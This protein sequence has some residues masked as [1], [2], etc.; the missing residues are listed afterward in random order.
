[1]NQVD[2]QIKQLADELPIPESG[3]HTAVLIDNEKTKVI[4]FS[5]ASVSS[6]IG[7]NRSSYVAVGMAFFLLLCA[8]YSTMLEYSPAF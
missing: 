1:M 3:R 5:F 4:L 2:Y 7:D 8:C 6:D